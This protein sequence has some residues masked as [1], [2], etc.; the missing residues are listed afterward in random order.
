MNVKYCFRKQRSST[1]G[2]SSSENATVNADSSNILQNEHDSDQEG[3]F[4]KIER[5]KRIE[6][7]VN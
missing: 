5:F 6:N 3:Y 4:E 7:E 1:I 2:N